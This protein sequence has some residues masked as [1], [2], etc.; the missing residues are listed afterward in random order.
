MNV[1]TA[2]IDSLEFLE[3]A[4]LDDI[5]YM[6]GQITNTGR[7]SMEIRV[8]C[9]I[10]K[11]NDRTRIATAYLVYVGL[12]SSETPSPVPAVEPVT[13]GE[14]AEFEAAAERRRWRLGRRT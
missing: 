4:H 14:K 7:T 5:I 8:D 6:V 9:F 10:E 2:A 1:T 12:D 13:D 3:G 11:G